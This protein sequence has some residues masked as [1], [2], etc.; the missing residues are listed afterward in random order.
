M[1]CRS[2]P[3]VV[4]LADFIKLREECG[5][6]AL[7]RI[8]EAPLILHW[9]RLLLS[10]LPARRLIGVVLARLGLGCDA[11]EGRLGA[12]DPQAIDVAAKRFEHVDPIGRGRLDFRDHADFGLFDPSVTRY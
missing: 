11:R 2:F 5:E 10:L 7:L 8:E 6:A 12:L 1:L 4:V 3:A 9:R